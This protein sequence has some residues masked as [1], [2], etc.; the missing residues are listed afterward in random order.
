MQQGTLEKCRIDQDEFGR[1][2]TTAIVIYHSEDSARNAIQ[3]LNGIKI[4]NSVIAVEYFKRD[5][6]DSRGKVA[7][8]RPI[9]KGF[10]KRFDRR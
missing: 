6:N 2:K 7:R 10:K 1:S 4:E 5:P 9:Q 8:Q 3:N